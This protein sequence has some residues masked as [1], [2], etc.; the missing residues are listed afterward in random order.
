MNLI[1]HS[2]HFVIL[3]FL[4]IKLSYLPLEKK[5]VFI[6]LDD[7]EFTIRYITDAIPNS[8]AGHQ[9][10]TQAKQNLGIIAINEEYP[11]TSQGELDELNH[12][13]N[14]SRNFKV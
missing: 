13:Q 5:L 8:P 6:L 7:D 4:Q 11:T 3:K 9:L 12:H 10:L 1:L 14:P 2:L